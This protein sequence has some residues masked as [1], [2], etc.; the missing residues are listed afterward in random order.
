MTMLSRDAILAVVDLPRE[1]VAVPEWGGSVIV[2]GLSAQQRDKVETTLR[3]FRDGEVKMRE[4]GLTDFRAR[5]VALCVINEDGSRM[6]SDDDISAL[7]KKSAIAVERVADVAL[8]LSGMTN[9]AVE[10]AEKN[11]DEASSDD[12][13]SD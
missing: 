8:R 11:S 2:Q 5:I 12:S 10:S 13:S 7:G 9:E 3:D 4:K 6:F 1:E